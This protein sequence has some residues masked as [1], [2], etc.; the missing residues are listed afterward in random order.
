[1]ALRLIVKRIGQ[2][3]AAVYNCHRIKLSL[4]D[5]G[6]AVKFVPETIHVAEGDGF[7]NDVLARSEFGDRLTNLVLAIGTPSTLLLDGP[8]GV[9]KSTFVQMWADTAKSKGMRVIYFNAFDNDYLNDAFTAIAGEFLAIHAKQSNARERFVKAAVKFGKSLAVHGS[10]YAVKA[11]TLGVVDVL[12]LS[13]AAKDVAKDIGKDAGD[14]TEAALEARLLARN[15]ERSVMEGFRSE[16]ASFVAEISAQ[17]EVGASDAVPPLVFIIDELDRCKPD[18]ALA[19][20]ESI[21]HLFAV[22]GIV[23][24]LVTNLDQLCSAVQAT[25]G[26]TL[27]ARSYLEKFYHLLIHLPEPA[28]ADRENR[29]GK[30]LDRIFADLPSDVQG[31]HGR[32][33]VHEL[34]TEHLLFLHSKR[35]MSL[36]KLERLATQIAVVYASTRDNQLRLAPL[37]ADLCLM[38]SDAPQL[39]ARARNGVLAVTDLESFLPYSQWHSNEPEHSMRHVQ[40]AANLWRYFLGE[41]LLGGE[42]KRKYGNELVRYGLPT[43]MRL[44][45]LM[46]DWIDGFAFPQAGPPQVTS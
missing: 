41:E 44:I 18:F 38:K 2:S 19:L 1:M 35:I 6:R 10:R 42:D 26:A 3:D 14:A 22:H 28:R 17:R 7:K 31:Q 39:Y 40:W 43:P 13:E 15:T 33:R 16:L 8:W 37:I 25:Y 23:F 29:L 45:S 27:D 30:F 46:C 5:R 9:G 12:D 24:L 20:V 34:I 36:R 21:K 32:G 11:A 4:K